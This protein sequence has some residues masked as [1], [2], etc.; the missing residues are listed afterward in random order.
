MNPVYVTNVVVHNN[1]APV[2]APF[3]FQVSFESVESLEHDLEWKLIYVGSASDK[4]YDQELDAVSLGP[5]PRG[6][7]QFTFV[8]SPPDFTKLLKEEIVG[9]TVVL[10]SGSYRGQEFVR[11]GWYLQNV[12]THVGLD[13]QDDV[14]VD[15]MA[16]EEM[17]SKLQRIIIADNP[18]VTRFNIDWDNTKKQQQEG[19]AALSTNNGLPPAS[20][21][22][23]DMED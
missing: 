4:S 13:E 9:I 22:T 17:L 5:I 10:L 8:A 11:I 21:S 14:D 18:R 23:C 2:T 12:F 20:G 19:D 16:L 6:A 1:P 15:D 7:L 3:E